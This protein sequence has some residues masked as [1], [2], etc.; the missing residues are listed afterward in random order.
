MKLDLKDFRKITLGCA[1]VSEENGKI[2][3][4]RFTEE[5]ELFYEKRDAMLGRS[6][7]DRCSAPSG[8]KLCFATDSKSLKIAVTT[9]AA[10]SRSYFSFDVFE[11]GK[12]LGYL[13]NFKEEELFENYTEQKFPLGKH[14][15]SFVLS[16]G[17]SEI[18][19]HFP[20]SVFIDDIEILLDDGASIEAIKPKKKLLLYGDSI[21]QGYDAI[22]PSNRY[23]ARIAEFLGAEE[24]N[25]AIGGE[26]FVPPLVKEKLVFVPDCI[27]VAYGTNDWSTT[28][29]KE[30][31]ENVKSFYGFLSKNYPDVPIFAITPIWRLNFEEAKPFGDFFSVEK[32]IREVTA[33]LENVNVISGFDLVSHDKKL[34]ADLRLHP[35]DDGFKEYFKNL[36]KKIG[37]LL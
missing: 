12:L 33:G 27:T 36:S 32:I 5:E 11:N 17:R 30:F 28:D 10:T 29:G 7:K 26:V 6:F 2:R 20:W 16:E 35:R 13:D 14:E 3:F 25:K 9:G 31:Y 37:E 21:T 34:F 4:H 24:I 8:I 18:T 1:S 23:A 15:K 19:V 22:R